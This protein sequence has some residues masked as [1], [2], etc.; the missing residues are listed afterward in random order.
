MRRYFSI[1][2]CACSLMLACFWC[3]H[4]HRLRRWSRAP[5]KRYGEVRGRLCRLFLDSKPEVLTVLM[6]AIVMA[7]WEFGNVVS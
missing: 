4:R 7:G 1:R 3:E 2:R 6:T 5:F